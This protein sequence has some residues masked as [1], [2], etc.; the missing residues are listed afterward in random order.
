[1]FSR[2]LYAGT[3]TDRLTIRNPFRLFVEPV[4]ECLQSITNINGGIVSQHGS[5]LRNVCTR[6][7]YIA[8][9]KR[10]LLDP[11]A[12]AANALQLGNQLAQRH[13]RFVAEIEDL[14][15]KG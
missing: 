11:N 1:M 6:S 7:A 13:A 8:G 14:K 3:T 2:S 9:L 10:E 4:D 5:R 15:W 12:L